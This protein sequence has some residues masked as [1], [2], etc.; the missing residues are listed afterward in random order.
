MALRRVAAGPTG[1]AAHTPSRQPDYNDEIT[2]EQYEALDR[3]RFKKDGTPRV[4]TPLTEAG[5]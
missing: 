3:L 2:K 5:W 4:F 1:R